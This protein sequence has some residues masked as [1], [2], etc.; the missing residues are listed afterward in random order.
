MVSFQ[1]SSETLSNV[2]TAKQLPMKEM[3]QL[4]KW[5]QLLEI[6]MVKCVKFASTYTPLLHYNSIYEPFV[7]PATAGQAFLFWSPPLAEKA[8]RDTDSTKQRKHQ[9]LSKKIP[10]K[11]ILMLFEESYEL[12]AAKLK[13]YSFKSSSFCHICSKHHSF[14]SCCFKATGMSALYKI[15]LKAGLKIEL[16]IEIRPWIAADL[17]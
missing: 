11:S 16:I 14:K 4:C 5:W 1:T 15:S 9:E 17:H 8:E 3:I 13:G 12:A 10:L 6:W 7:L 2:L